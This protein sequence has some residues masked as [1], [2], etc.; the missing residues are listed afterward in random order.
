MKVQ[1]PIG[2]FGIL[3]CGA[4]LAR[5]RRKINRSGLFVLL[6]AAAA[7][8]FG[9]SLFGPQEE[10]QFFVLGAMLAVLQGCCLCGLLYLMKE[11]LCR[12]GLSGAYLQLPPAVVIL[13]LAA[14]GMIPAYQESDAI[15]RDYSRHDR[16]NDLMRYMDTSLAPGMYISPGDNHNTFNR[17]WGGYTGVHDFKWRHPYALLFDRPIDEWRALGVE[18]AIMPHSLMLKDPEVYYPEETVLLKT[19]PVD[20]SFRGPDM[21][22]LRLYPMQNESDAR[23][24]PIRLL[25]YDI[26]K[27]KLAPGEEIVFRQYWQPDSPTPTVHNIGNY[28]LNGDG[29]VVAQ[30]DWVP[31]WDA[32]RDTTTWDDPDEILLGREFALSLPVDLPP[33][34]YRLAFGFY[35]STARLL[36]PDGSALAEITEITVTAP[37]EARLDQQL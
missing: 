12:L 14:I 15:A 26:N 16:R 6:L 23:L 33:A 13:A 19:Y 2:W 24:G 37:A 10:R 31:L 17:A 27:T 3:L 21:V 4:L 35:D 32:R 29:E 8:L 25:G 18:Y 1:P 9:I 11:A 28:L 7:F 34:T 20:P 36:S 22:V 5:Y 30:V